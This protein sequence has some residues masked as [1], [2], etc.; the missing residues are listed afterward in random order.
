[1]APVQVRILPVAASCEEF[2]AR[3]A[4]ELRG[5]MFRAEV[6]A[7]PESFNKRLRTAAIQKVPNVLVIGQREVAA[8]SVTW[9]RHAA[10]TDQRVVP[11][12]GLLATLER[13]RAD[14]V[15]D[16][17]PDVIVEVP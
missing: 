9:R 10:Q 14:R 1:M 4:A 15:M 6:D 12:A 2:A 16:N 5:R 7:G 17:F 8:E 13:L 11:V 3:L